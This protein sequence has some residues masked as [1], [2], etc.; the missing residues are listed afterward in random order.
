M[1]HRRIASVVGRIMVSLVLIFL[2]FYMMLPAI[3]LHDQNFIVFLIISILIVLVVNFLTYV[4][5]FLSALGQSRRTVVVGHDPITGAP[6]YGVNP[7]E[8]SNP[9]SLAKPLK[10]GFILIAILVVFMAVASLIGIK[11]FNASRYRDLIA[12]T[13]GD[14][15]ADVSE[16]NM[17]QIP[18][19]DRDTASR[20]G[21][22][23]LGEMSE[24]VSQF[25][26]QE[27]YTQI[28]YHQTP[29]RVTPLAYADP[30][31]WL[32]NQKNGLP[33]YITVNMVTQDTDL[34][35]LESG[36]RYSPSEYF[37]R[38]IYRYLRFSYPTLMFDQVSFEIDDNGTPYWVAPVITYRIGW[39]SGK[40]IS[41]AVLVDACTGESQYYAKEDVPQW[42]DQLYNSNLIIEQLDDNGRYQNGYLN[43]I[44]GQRGVRRTTYGYNYLA[45]DDD[46]YLYTGMSSVTADESNIGFVLVN[47][48]TKE[49][50]FYPVPG[51]TE[52]SAMDSAQGQVQH[53]KY[54]ATFPLLLNIS[55][56]PTY[57]ISL[58]DAAGLVK[59]YAFVDVAQYQI[60]GTG[61][62]ID[63]ARH[64]YRMALNLEDEIV[65][66]PENE[67]T[68][69]GTVE[70][71][72]DVVLSGNSCYYFMLEGDSRIYT[73]LITVSEQL[74]FLRTG[75]KV[76]FTYTS[77]GED[78]DTGNVN[79]IEI[80]EKA[81]EGAEE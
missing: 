70:S 74:P 16:I 61:V 48:R 12:I 81:G 29:Y 26:I 37:F 75:D 64:N 66:E 41:G 10:Y 77:S 6:V 22:R 15:T 19:V 20:L 78:G 76:S 69:S 46:V 23:K 57:F 59:M 71:V 8:S 40:D 2:L 44:F 53:L 72:A 43:S 35:W 62:T 67:M 17:N 25:E 42:I 58:K 56:R 4:K 3:N 49:T 5:N 9:V 7:Q 14:F 63:E 33:A 68:A 34:V 24:L 65:T 1:K 47:L 54:T 13:D 27:H 50:R 21:S 73:A 31:K 45:L 30:I 18:V 38:N 36:M 79:S 60:V 39:W 55:D 51:A 28:N 80:T 52:Y 11:F 32:F